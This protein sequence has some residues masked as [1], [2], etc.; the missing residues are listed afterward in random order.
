MHIPE[1]P[2]RL[3]LFHEDRGGFRGWFIVGTAP[4]QRMKVVRRLEPRCLQ[5]VESED[6][7][8]GLADYSTYH[9]PYPPEIIHACG[10][11]DFTL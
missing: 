4:K 8:D 1:Q 2:R 11:G 9:H 10:H 3:F 5:S 6:H 7:V